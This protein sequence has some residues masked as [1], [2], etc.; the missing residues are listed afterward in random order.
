MELFRQVWLVLM[1]LLVQCG[2]PPPF[3]VASKDFTTLEGTGSQAG[4]RQIVATVNFTEPVDTTSVVL[5]VSLVVWGANDPNATGTATWKNNFST[6]VF[7]S[8]KPWGEIVGTTS[9][10]RLRFTTARS[11]SGKPLSTN[12]AGCKIGPVTGTP[13]FTQPGPNECWLWFHIV[14]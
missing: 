5:G 13:P 4:T 1:L 11:Q 2:T 14:G 3:E 9:D 8:A 12:T 10:F 6:L 7:T